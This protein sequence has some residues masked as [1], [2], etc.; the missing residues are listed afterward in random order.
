MDAILVVTNLPDEQSA[1][2]LAETLVG[3]RLAACV[4]ILPPCRS[5]Y[6]WRGKIEA[7]PEY[8]VWIKT[9]REHYGKVE[10]TI[11]Q[12]HPYEL[13]E[14]IAVP[15]ADGLPAYLAW[16]AAETRTDC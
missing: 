7:A 16:V 14:I 2:R 11:R 4:N 13:P 1:E 15:L 9:L 5:V 8:P 10:D 3:A 6:R 12:N